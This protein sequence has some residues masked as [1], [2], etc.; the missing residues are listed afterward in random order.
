VAD[1]ADDD[2][3]IA[4]GQCVL[5]GALQ[6]REH[7]IEPGAAGG[8]APMLD[9]VPGRSEAP[10]GEV[11]RQVLLRRREHVHHERAVAAD[12]P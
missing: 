11:P 2:L 1:A 12:C 5:H 6:R 8:P 3:V 9:P 10:P 4:A 7:I